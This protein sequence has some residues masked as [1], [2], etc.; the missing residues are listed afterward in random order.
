MIAL[1]NPWSTPS[2]APLPMAL[3]ALGSML[4][5]EFDYRII[6]GNIDSDPVG[7]ITALSGRHRLTAI[8]ITTMIG[9]QLANAHQDVACVEAAAA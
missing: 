1:V 6:D 4:E 7:T 2:K 9:P 8:A 5:G 3:L